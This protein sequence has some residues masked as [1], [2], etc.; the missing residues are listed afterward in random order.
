[1]K[2]VSP[3][4]RELP[5]ITEAQCPGCLEYYS[6]TGNGTLRMHRK[7]VGGDPCP[8]A[9]DLPVPRTARLRTT[10]KRYRSP[11]RRGEE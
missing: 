5:R 10:V 4:G 9:G 11:S 7:H 6:V 1:M 3:R 8:G 2:L